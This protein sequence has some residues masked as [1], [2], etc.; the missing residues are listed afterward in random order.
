M[1]ILGEEVPEGGLNIFQNPFHP[2]KVSS[3]HIAIY[4]AGPEIRAHVNFSSGN[5]TGSQSFRDYRSLFK[6]LIDIDTFIKTL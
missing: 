6:L 1:K 4:S 3:I 5:T 2:D